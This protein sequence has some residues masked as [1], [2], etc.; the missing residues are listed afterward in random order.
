MTGGYGENMRTF[1][2]IVS[3]IALCA[4]IGAAAPP[5]SAAVI[6]VPGDYSTIQAA[7]DNAS[8]GDLINVY[9]GT[10]PEYVT[11]GTTLTL[12][13]YGN[14][15][16]QGDRD[17]NQDVVA[18]NADNILF[19]GFEV[20]DSD[21]SH[22]A[23]GISG[24]GVVIR[25][26]TVTEN[27]G[28]GI[29]VHGASNA[30]IQDCVVT[31]NGF[32]GGDDQGIYLDAA[33]NVTVE[34]TTIAGSASNNIYMT[35]STLCTIRENVFSSGADWYESILVRSGSSQNTIADNE[36]RDSQYATGIYVDT[37]SGN[38]ITGNTISNCSVESGYGGIVL[39]VSHDTVCSGN[40]IENC[41]NEDGAANAGIYITGSD[42]AIVS[43][44]TITGSGQ[45]G[46]LIESCEYA[47]ITGNTLSNNHFNFGLTGS[48]G[49]HYHYDTHTIDTSNT[50]DGRYIVY[51]VGETGTTIGPAQNAGTVCCVNCDD[52]TVEDL[53]LSNTYNGVVLWG[54]TNAIVSNVSVATCERGIDLLSSDNATITDVSVTDCYYGFHIRYAT[55]NT[56]TRSTVSDPSYRGIY[57]DQ[58]SSGNTIYLNTLSGSST[59]VYSQAT[60]TLWNSPTTLVYYYNGTEQAPH[61][62]GNHWADYSGS[63][64]DGDGIGD[65]IFAISTDT[66]DAYPLIAPHT[67]YTFAANQPPSASFT[68]LPLLPNS[69]QSTQFTD[70]S[71]DP[72]GTIA[73]WDW[74]FGDTGTSTAEDP[75]HVYAAP[76]W[77]NVTLNVTDDLGATDSASN[78]FFVHEPGPMTIWVPDNA[79][80]IQGGV[81]MARDGDTIMV[82]NGTYDEN[83]TVTKQVTMTGLGWP[84]INGTGKINDTVRLQSDNVVFQGF[85]V[86]SA[87]YAGVYVRLNN[88]TEVRDNRI[89]ESGY[90]GIRVRGSDGA[91]LFNNTV[92]NNSW[93]G[94]C[95]E[96]S[97]GCII[98]NNTCDFN[99][100]NGIYLEDVSNSVVYFND[101]NNFDE[102]TGEF[103]NAAEAGTSPSTNRW[104]NET[105][106]RGNRYS[107]Y[108]GIDANGDGVGDTPYTIPGGE[109][110]S[111]INSDPYPLMPTGPAPVFPPTITKITVS[112]I[113]ADSASVRWTIGNDVESNSRVLYGTDEG[114]AGAVWSGWDNATT[115]PS[116]PLTGLA[117]N[118]TYYYQC[119]SERTDD[120]D[121]NTTSGTGNFTTLE[122]IPMVITVDDDDGDI[123]VPPA[124]FTNITDAIA[125]SMDGDTILVYAGN[126]SGYHEVANRVNLTGIGWPEVSG[127]PDNTLDELG[128]VFALRADGCILDGFVIRDGWFHNQSGYHTTTDSA[129]VRIGYLSV[130]ADDTIVRN[131]RI[132]D[133]KYGI[134]A[135]SYAD[136]NTIH[137]NVI[138]RNNFGVWLKNAQNTLFA[139]NT[140]TNMVYSALENTYWKDT[141]ENYA[142]NN[143]IEYN[144]F[145]D[146][147]WAYMGGYD[148]S[149]GREVVIS[150]TGGN[151]IAHNTLLNQ[152]YIG[153][154]G[155]GN[156]IE[157]N[158]VL[159]PGENAE[160][161]IVIGENANIV[162]N[163]TIENHRFGIM[164]QTDADNLQMSGNTI[165]RCTYGFGFE[166]DV[167]YASSRPSRNVIDTTNTVEGAPIYWIV[168]ATG[169][170]YNYTTLS[171]APG[172]LALIGCSDI[173][174]ENFYPEKNAQSFFIYRSQNVTLDSV[175][176]HGSALQGI[177]IGESDAITIT[178]SS[179]DSNG[180]D[181]PGGGWTA[182]ILANNMTRSRIV[183]STVTANN[184][185]GIAFLYSGADNVISGCRITNNGEPTDA[186]H[187]YGIWD[188]D[189]IHNTTVTGCTIGNTFANVQGIGIATNTDDSLFYNNRFLNHT[190]AHAQ[191]WGTGTRWNIT[192][193]AG[194]NILGGPW[195]AGNYW[196][197]YAGED[198]NGDGLGDTLVPYTTGGATPGQDDHPLLDTFVPDTDPPVIIVY[199][200]VEGAPYPSAAVPLEVFS[201]DGDVAAWWY[202]LDSAANVTFTPNT[203]LTSLAVGPHTLQVWVSDTSGN[204]NST[205]RN[206]TAEEDTTPPAL[207]VTSPEENATYTA[208]AVP[209]SVWSPDADV[210][211]WWF[212]LDN[213]TDTPFVPNT[214]LTGLTNGNHTLMVAVDDIVGNVNATLVNFT[215]DAAV[216]YMGGDDGDDTP[217]G[218]VLPPVTPEF[219]ITILT[220]E[221]ARMTDRSCDL[222]YESPAPLARVFYQVDSHDPVPASPGEP[223]P[224]ERLTL[225]SHVIYVTGVDYTGHWGRGSVRFEVIPLALGEME[226]VGTDEFPDEAA[227]G[228]N[229]QAAPYTLRFEAESSEDIAVMVNRHLVGTCGVDAVSDAWL[230]Q[231]GQVETVAGPSGGWRS[232]TV[233]IPES[234]VV[235]ETEN[236]ISF[237]HTQNPD[238]PEGL[239]PWQARNVRLASAL[240]VSAPSIE[241]YT[242]DQALGPDDELMA[243]IR[244][245]GVPADEAYTAMVYLAGPDGSLHAFPGGGEPAPLDGRYVRDNHFGRLPGAV[246]LGAGDLSG[247]YR[248]VATLSPEGS[249]RLVSLSSVPVYFST[250]PSVR[251]FLNR[252]V[253]TD[254]L[255]VRVAC[256]VTGGETPMNASL[257]TLLEVPTGPDLYLP[258]G[259]EA[260]SS[261]TYA[262]LEPAFLS[263]LEDTIG[264]GYAEGAYRL[265]SLLIDEEGLVVAEDT[266]TF[267]VAREEGTLVVRFADG[268]ARS[269]LAVT[270]TLT[271][272]TTA[273][274]TT[275]TSHTEVRFP[276]PPGT[277]WITGEVTT[278]DG[279]TLLIPADTGNRVAVPAGEE[280]WMR[281]VTQPLPPFTLPEV[282]P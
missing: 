37:S 165:A 217:P 84:V 78:S 210:F 46:L 103:H 9:N 227:F 113:T 116:F 147:G 131:N 138:D 105:L 152:T 262:P 158:E 190:V 247:T 160:A 273:A 88:N 216:P 280:V 51:L 277:Y 50:V 236:I 75:I 176:A 222:T 231:N 154:E 172:Y 245:M 74:D 54:T 219:D 8:P 137:H 41:G 90:W 155:D 223:V 181:N 186:E 168:G 235:P 182:G 255:P 265:S 11:V 208:S 149:Y 275:D 252:E 260:S 204:E 205:V 188:Y 104:Y 274:K 240:T 164:L 114:L 53:V 99:G 264:S 110:A 162:C 13:G 14:P 218:V 191:N 18:L 59:D 166:G 171:P 242:P 2:V 253:F 261:I 228:F 33:T 118:T 128:D 201:P 85:E 251:L 232:Y 203:T 101:L 233:E 179:I 29:Y 125:A 48:Y 111:S 5:V 82:R 267:T 16:I 135:N 77:Y 161:G 62:L 80:T 102:G 126:Y 67:A 189:S 66:D 246:R 198:L 153:I 206:F 6:S 249:E 148:P 22:G 28:Q 25:N 96:D 129:G 79:T 60:D 56:I 213:G 70:T 117:W 140:V 183:N 254:G 10:Y 145:D 133:S 225:G 40:I 215:V 241:V 278:P 63:D 209:L 174:V 34:R 83:I 281:V 39:S 238:R 112:G 43:S 21:S 123:P 89:L 120:G 221:P 3:A 100:D 42:N 87:E 76:G 27:E 45:A 36:I 17:T 26:C 193:V 184:P 97:N 157:E 139:N 226:T 31:D 276:L 35:S 187:S 237:I 127:D 177:L 38:I 132:E 197:D 150:D 143:R 243:W 279:E 250:E 259:T 156:T 73:S 44:N 271:F 61:Y 282:A 212:A 20:T 266:A 122:R 200:P 175:S 24:A 258:A 170:V 202:S 64:G 58:Y 192:P 229:G 86:R 52:V 68:W 220:P 248:L 19:D 98:H 49:Y 199:S 195:I 32:G 15:I 178:G 23:I 230:P 180:Y 167:A 136:N 94:I 270:D 268:A 244:I 124:D 142:T 119:Y 91:T 55:D 163:N 65:T 12:Q 93:D 211:S 269:R 257:V 121:Y 141:T 30:I 57:Q 256:A 130:P 151:V 173:R 92:N 194:T 134:I 47:A 69:T 106:M 95:I 144:T 224:I 272:R 108:D 115:T 109:E 169:Q 1:F 263:M 4:A 146:A 196:D 7:V 159:G 107:D 234:L 207:Y 239:G 81:D 214:T 72:D 71:V 185:R